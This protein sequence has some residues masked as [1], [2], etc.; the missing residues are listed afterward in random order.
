MPEEATLQNPAFRAAYL[1]NERQA[2]INTGKVASALVF[3]LMP[4]GIVL[5]YAMYPDRLGDFLRLRLLSS[6]LAAGLDYLHTIP[7]GQ[8]HVKWLGV[9]IALLPAGFIALMIHVKEG[10]ISPYYAGLNLIL[11]A[12][13]VVVRWNTVESVIAVGGVILMYTAA[14][15]TGWTREQWGIIFNNYYFLVETGIIV[16][17][18]NH[19]FN[20]LRFREFALRYELDR[21]RKALEE[22]NQKLQ[23]LD[24]IKGRFFANISHELRTPLTLLLSPLETM[25]HSRQ[26]K[27][28]AETRNLMSIMHGNGMRLLK[29]INDLLDLVRLESGRMEVK[30]EPLEMA[31]FVKGLMGAALQ[32]AQAKG[33]KL[34]TTVAAGLGPVLLDRDKL[35]KMILN[36]VFNA[37]KSRPPAAW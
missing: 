14:C 23:E 8:R 20:R 22:S 12:A 36:L 34:E 35:E 1:A 21:N 18:G 5:D 6:A 7:F 26:T 15:L 17:V 25:L 10:P 30:R 33:V 31:A 4:A 27:F 13:S 19:F 9:P 24:Q 2:R 32:M 16:V 3:F 28:D 37:L 29:L 11:L